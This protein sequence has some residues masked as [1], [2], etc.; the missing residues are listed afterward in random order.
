MMIMEKKLYSI[1]DVQVTWLNTEDL[2]AVSS[3]SDRPTEA[4]QAPPRRTEVF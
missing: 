1:P 2:M 4:N 3:G